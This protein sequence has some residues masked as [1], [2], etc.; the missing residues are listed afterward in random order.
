MKDNNQYPCKLKPTQ[1][2]LLLLLALQSFGCAE[3]EIKLTPDTI[4]YNY[5]GSRI[6]V[7]GCNR[8][9]GIDWAMIQS[10]KYED[11]EAQGL[12]VC[13]KCPVEGSGNNYI[14]ALEMFNYSLPPDTIVYRSLNDEDDYTNN[15]VRRVHVEGCQRLE[16]ARAEGAKFETITIADAQ[17]AGLPPCTKCPV[18]LGPVEAS[19][20]DSVPELEVEEAA[21]VPDTIVYIDGSKTVHVEGCSSMPTDR[22][23][24]AFMTKLIHAEAEA[25]GYKLCSSCPGSNTAKDEK[26]LKPDADKNTTVMVYA[27]EGDKYYH[28]VGCPRLSQQPEVWSNLSPISRKEATAMGLKQCSRCP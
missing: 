27:K 10:M 8:L 22:M 17:I 14:L 6:H 3:N 25:Q 20:L 12:E 21:I 23:A 18:E 26:V 7:T 1:L 11:A 15:Q 16:N 28:V 19:S 13:S 5:G 9:V 2:A 4:V 24:R